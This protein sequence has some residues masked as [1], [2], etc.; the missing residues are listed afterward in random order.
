VP[1]R[2]HGGSS[3]GTIGYCHGYDAIKLRAAMAATDPSRI[4]EYRQDS[5]AFGS[6]LLKIFGS[7]AAVGAV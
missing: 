2:N 6:E 5:N 3:R 4:A 7:T 1:C